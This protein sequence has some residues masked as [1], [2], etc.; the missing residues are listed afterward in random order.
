MPRGA[1]KYRAQR[2]E[3]ANGHSHPSKAEAKRCDELHLLQKAGAITHLE[4]QPR[5]PI[6]IEGTLV[7]TYVADFSYFPQEPERSGRVIE[8]VKGHP[9][10]V[11]RLKKKLVEAYYR[12]T[13]IVEVRR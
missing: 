7:C 11:Y 5:F 3:C 1:H 8:D 13:K 9:T 6:H 12:G 10:P 2:T 4:L